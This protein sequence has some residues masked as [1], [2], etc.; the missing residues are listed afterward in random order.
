MSY[1]VKFQIFERGRQAS[2]SFFFADTV[3]PLEGYLWPAQKLF[4]T[5]A[6]WSVLKIW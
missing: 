5:V 4:L 2:L 6:D 3:N 1:L